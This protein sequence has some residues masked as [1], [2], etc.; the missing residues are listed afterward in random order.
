MEETLTEAGAKVILDD[1]LFLASN[2]ARTEHA[3]AMVE[4]ELQSGDARGLLSQFPNL[5]D[6]YGP[7]FR[8][9]GYTIV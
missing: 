2:V 1:L 8:T 6:I 4:Y 3:K 9:F 5:R 7:R